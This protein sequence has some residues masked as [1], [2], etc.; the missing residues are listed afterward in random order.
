M[1]YVDGAS[2][3]RVGVVSQVNKATV[4]RWLAAARQA[5]LAQVLEQVRHQTGTTPE[6]LQSVLR[7][8]QSQLDVS[9]SGA[10]Q[11]GV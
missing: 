2:L 5:L 6:E 4:S 7:Q 1:H 8:I 11:E 3:E 10:L 9:L